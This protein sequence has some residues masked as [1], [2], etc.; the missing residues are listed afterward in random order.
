MVGGKVEAVEVKTQNSTC[1]TCENEGNRVLSDTIIVIDCLK[2]E[3]LRVRDMDNWEGGWE[4]EA[5]RR[6]R[7]C[8]N[9]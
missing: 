5:M 9:I 2:M 6:R 3:V 4:Q 7:R 8:C 1:A